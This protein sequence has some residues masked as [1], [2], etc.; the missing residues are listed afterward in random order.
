M[1]FQQEFIQLVLGET[2]FFNNQW[3][4]CP[5]TIP[6]RSSLGDV[7]FQSQSIRLMQEIRLTT[8]EVQSHVD[9]GI[10]TIST[11][12][13]RISSI[14][15]VWNE[16]K[17]HPA[18]TKTPGTSRRGPLSN[19]SGGWRLSSWKTAKKGTYWAKSWRTW[20]PGFFLLHRETLVDW[21]FQ[22]GM[23]WAKI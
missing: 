6:G 14:K 20:G 15:Y 13:R 17:I 16:T 22:T 8:W 19:C 2:R 5:E 1:H 9:N 10:V 12:D 3:V 23:F 21:I 11:G 4:L 18:K 7:F